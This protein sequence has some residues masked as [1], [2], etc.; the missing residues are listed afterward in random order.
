M[1]AILSLN[2]SLHSNCKSTRPFSF[3]ILCAHLGHRMSKSF[4]PRNDHRIL[5]KLVKMQRI[6]T[7]PAN[8]T[9]SLGSVASK[10]EDALRL[11]AW[12][13]GKSLVVERSPCSYKMVII[14]VWNLFS[15]S[16][17]AS[18]Q[19]G[20]ETQRKPCSAPPRAG[21]YK[22]ALMSTCWIEALY[23]IQWDDKRTLTKWSNALRF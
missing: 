9:V 22:N 11:L 20:R 23:S 7:Q 6:L 13:C 5:K 14:N 1:S 16:G 21:A 19:E 12:P 8:T 10:R 4:A 18:V 17:V 3:R 15:L 2:D